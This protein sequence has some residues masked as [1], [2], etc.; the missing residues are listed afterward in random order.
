MT[1][2]IFRTAK[3]AVMAMVQLFSMYLGETPYG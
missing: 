1:S 3:R 2:V